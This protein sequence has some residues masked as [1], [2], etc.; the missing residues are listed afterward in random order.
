MKNKR[1]IVVGRGSLGGYATGIQNVMSMI[2][3]K[4]RVLEIC[5]DLFFSF[6][7]ILLSVPESWM[8]QNHK[9]P[10]ILSINIVTNKTGQA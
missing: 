7:E 6:S 1:E 9:S 5:M 4:K 10:K 2:C 3:S 8:G